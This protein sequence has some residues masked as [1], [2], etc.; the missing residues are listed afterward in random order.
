[1]PTFSYKGY[2]FDVDHTPTEQEFAQMS[3]YVDTLPP[4]QTKQSLVDQIPGTAQQ[5]TNEPEPSFMDKAL[6]AGEAALSTATG[7]VGGGLAGAVGGL[8]GI[9]DSAMGGTLGTQ[10]GVEQSGDKFHEQ[11]AMA[12]YEPRTKVGKE[13]AGKVGQFITEQAPSLVAIAPQLEQLSLLGKFNKQQKAAGAEIQKAPSADAAKLAE[14][15]AKTVE[16]AKMPTE[17]GELDLGQP[18]QYGHRPSEFTVDENGIPIRRDASLEA[19]ETVRGGDLFSR[20]NQANELRN[21]V[22]NNA[23]AGT[24]GVPGSRAYL[25]AQEEELAYQQKAKQD[26][27][28]SEEAIAEPAQAGGGLEKSGTPRNTALEALRKRHGGSVNTGFSEAVVDATRAVIEKV[29]EG[30]SGIKITP[31]LSKWISSG[32]FSQYW[33]DFKKD[34]G[35]AWHQQPQFKIEDGKLTFHTQD[36]QTVEKFLNYM[37][38]TPYGERAGIPPKVRNGASPLGQTQFGKGQKGSIGF[39]GKDP[40]EKFAENLRKEVPDVTEAELQKLWEEKQKQAGTAI[41]GQQ[42]A[43]HQSQ[44]VKDITGL[45]AKYTGEVWAPEKAIEV[46]STVPDIQNRGLLKEQVASSGRLQRDLL[47]HPTTTWVY[48]LTN[49]AVEQGRLFARKVLDDNGTGIIPKIRKQIMFNKGGEAEM[50]ALLKWRFDNEGTGATLPDTFSPNA[51]KINDALNKGDEHLLAKMNEVLARD[52]KKPIKNIDNHMVHYWS[53]P[54]RA[55]VYIKTPEGGSRLGFFVSEKTHGDAMKAMKWIKENIPNV[56]LEKTNGVKFVK[57]DA[58][59]RSSMFDHL[60]DLTNNTDAAVADALQAFK[61]RVQSVQERHLGE[62]NRQKHRAG[63][64]G[65]LGNKPWMTEG[66]NYADAVESIRTKYDAGYQW[67]AA[68]EIRQQMEPVLTAQQEGKIHVGEALSLGQKYVDHALGKN[69]DTSAI[70]KMMDYLEDISPRGIGA[71]R[72]GVTTMQH[73]FSRVTLPYLLALKG[74]QAVQSILQVGQATIPRMLEMQKVY[75]GDFHHIATSL[76]QGSMD[77]MFQFVN[78]VT[79]RKFE[80]ISRQLMQLADTDFSPTTQAIHNAIRDLDVARISLSDT[81]VSKEGGF[82][83]SWGNAAAEGFLDAPMNLF[84]GPTR[85]WAFSAFVRQ[86]V[87]DGFKLED[88]IKLGR[89]QMDTMVNYNPEAGAMGLA[90]LGIVGQ[91]ARGLHTFMVNY[92]T[93]L[94]RYGKMAIESGGKDTAP[95]LSYL[96]ITFALGGA[97]GFIGAD[98]ADWLLDGLKAGARGTQADSPELQKFNVR[99]WLM[100]NAP[101]VVSVGPLSTSTDLGLYG[102]F[103][104]KVVDPDRTF[105]DNMFPKTVASLQLAKAAMKA[106]LLLNKD[107]SD[108]ERG[109]I[110]EGI[111]PKYLTQTIRN[112]YQN[113]DNTVYDPNENRAGLP[114]YQRTDKEQQ[115]SRYGFG[116]RGLAETMAAADTGNYFQSQKNIEKSQKAQLD[117]LD[118]ILVASIKQGRD[119]NTDQRLEK[120]IQSLLVDWRMDDSQ[121][122]KHLESVAESYGMPTEAIR[123]LTKIKDAKLRDV[124]KI[125]DLSAIIRRT[126]ERQQKYGQRN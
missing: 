64:K 61:E 109:T 121:L 93:Q 123:K 117:K 66:R 86:A 50:R 34:T 78:T 58:R 118:Q 69:L 49:K 47:N 105:I 62:Q 54:Y 25:K 6:G 73:V 52:G 12:T 79:N 83:K 119:P 103:T 110:I 60:L 46:F 77:G 15:R 63:V 87:K 85:T 30:L 48:N 114:M 1:M 113:K 44:A 100:E 38:E 55:Y 92:Y 41:S 43:V 32:E 71:T 53:G 115:I 111:S 37:S 120:Q 99:Q 39:F 29:S 67:V 76:A 20:D 40:Y 56:D 89:E 126:N 51:R 124:D 28:F 106:P 10:K 11:A 31:A 36:A 75:N 8:Q 101:D 74:T 7:L 19:Q 70:T 97:V 18:N 26:S 95:L 84:E 102:S 65:F 24:E 9:L 3:A 116:V 96:A 108:K 72:R 23:E 122:Q 27:L 33:G 81:G 88:A 68:Q 4:K 90:N 107:L 21:D 2:D 45:D 59:G 57:S 17:Q 22:I 35:L 5:P 98:L 14:M 42:T 125:Q 82:W 80:G 112:R 94:S 104:T 16:Q 13:Y 91:E